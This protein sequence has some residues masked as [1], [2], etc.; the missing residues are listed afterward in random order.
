MP[1]PPGDVSWKGLNPEDVSWIELREVC[2]SEQKL[3]EV[4]LSEWQFIG[5][6]TKQRNV[7]FL[8][9]E[10]AG[11]GPWHRDILGLGINAF[12]NAFRLASK[13]AKT[14]SNDRY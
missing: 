5:P 4:L 6:M 9:A 11:F 2:T 12:R 7:F 1:K 14:C 8:P 13:L 10:T 3:E